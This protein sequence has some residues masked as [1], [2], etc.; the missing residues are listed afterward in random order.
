MKP[1]RIA[2]LAM[3]AAL[4]MI[5]AGSS[6]TDASAQAAEQK[7]NVSDADKKFLA[8]A[9]SI[10]LGEIML[11]HLAA[12]KGTAESV[13]NF[14]Q[15]MIVD[16]THGLD[17]LKQVASKVHVTLPTEVDAAT[18]SLYEDLSKK[19]GRDFDTAYID[20]MVSG[21]E[22]AVREFSDEATAGQNDAI[23]AY[24]QSELPM[25]DEHLRHARNLAQ[26][27]K[28]GIAQPQRR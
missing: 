17:A 12:K 3:T 16:H 8:D 13:R 7:P 25:L 21:H 28:P 5:F 23:K 6:L 15:R 9:F 11:G 22:S 10:N 27:Q 26:E 4:A 24:A 20:A 14:A 2:A 19:S 1:I 18:K